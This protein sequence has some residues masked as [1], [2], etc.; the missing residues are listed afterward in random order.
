MRSLCFFVST[1]V[2]SSFA[3]HCFS[4]ELYNT[5]ILRHSSRPSF[6]RRPSLYS[7]ECKKEGCGQSSINQKRAATMAR[8]NHCVIKYALP[9][10]YCTISTFPRTATQVCDCVRTITR[11]KAGGVLIRMV[12]LTGEDTTAAVKLVIQTRWAR[13]RHGEG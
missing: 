2:A 3:L 13:C 11:A 1:T 12:R 8:I 6:S 9:H 7:Y 10:L 5:F 4:A